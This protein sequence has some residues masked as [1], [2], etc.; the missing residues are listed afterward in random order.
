M[1]PVALPFLPLPLLWPLLWLWPL[2]A[3]VGIG[4]T[5]LEPRSEEEVAVGA[6][7]FVVKDGTVSTGLGTGTGTWTA[8]EEEGAVAMEVGS[9]K[10]APGMPPVKDA[11]C[12]RVEEMGVLAM[13]AAPVGRGIDE[14][15]G[16]GNGEGE[17]EG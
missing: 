16:G 11:G 2:L 12:G 5:A 7:V 4:A 14:I 17:G 15:S 9:V 8:T 13:D 1:R 3:T 10:E 6:A